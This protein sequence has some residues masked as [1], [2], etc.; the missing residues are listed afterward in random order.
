MPLGCGA[1]SSTAIMVVMAAF[2]PLPLVPG[3]GGAQVVRLRHARR[4]RD[5]I[6][7]S[8]QAPWPR[9]GVIGSMASPI[10]ATRTG[11]T[12]WLASGRGCGSRRCCPPVSPR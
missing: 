8:W 6:R 3:Q 10:S 5:R 7:D 4:Q 11:S 2:A 1:P 12:S 9:S